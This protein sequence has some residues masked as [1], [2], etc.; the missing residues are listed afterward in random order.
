M[1]ER[2]H[3]AFLFSKA[4]VAPLKPIT[5]PRL[6]LTTAVVAVRTVPVLLD[7]SPVLLDQSPV[8]L[9]QSPV[10]PL[11]PVCQ[12]ESSRFHFRDL[13]YMIIFRVGPEQYHLQKC[14]E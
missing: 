11:K 9:D 8:L 3:V 6:E 2:V 14:G 4:R 13:K 5:I 12:L 7:Q 1:D 10:P